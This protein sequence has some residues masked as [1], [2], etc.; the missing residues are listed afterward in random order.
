M[1]QSTE[2]PH[3]SPPTPKQDL[4]IKISHALTIG[5]LL[6]LAM[7]GLQI[8]NSNP[9]FGG[10]AGWHFPDYL[11]LGEWLAGGRNWHFAMVWIFSMNLLIYGIYIGLTKRWKKR[12]IAA[13]DIKVLQSGQNIKRK[14]YAWHRLFYTVIIPFLLI[15]IGS[16][17]A[18]YKPAQ[19]PWLAT[20]FG[21]WQTVRTIHFMTIPIVLVFVL[22]HSF[23]GLKVGGLR[24]IRSMFL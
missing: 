24:L 12:F 6:I 1:T 5:S 8:Y 11:L 18:M 2:K 15:A 9:V 23:M 14:N 17:L 22:V 7:S 13:S 16:G 20:F 10:R 19:L 4:F 21:S 3:K